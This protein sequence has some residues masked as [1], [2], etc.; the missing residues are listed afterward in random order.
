MVKRCVKSRVIHWKSLW[1]T[2][3]FR[4]ANLKID[5]LDLPFW[6]YVSNT[7]IDW[8]KYKSVSA[9]MEMS[10][11]FETHILDF[12]QDIYWKEIKVYAGKFL[13]DNKK[14]DDLD[15][16]KSAISLDTQLAS[17]DFV[18]MAFWTFDEVHLWH[19][20][21]L[22]EAKKYAD[23]LVV[24]VSRDET[25]EKIKWHKTLNNEKKRLNDIENLD[26][27]DAV[28]LWEKDDYFHHIKLINPDIICLWYDQDSLITKSLKNF[29]S[30]NRLNIDIITIKPYNPKHFKSSIIKQK[31]EVI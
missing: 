27:A 15:T 16:L 25:V 18:A 3:W 23:R 12:N 9:Y 7:F 4:T 10:W 19:S 20:F 31:K 11:I 5:N 22:N 13:R 6:V 21:F 29:I 30:E 17:Q 8:K 2:L 24:V 26:I 14:F 1:R 28:I